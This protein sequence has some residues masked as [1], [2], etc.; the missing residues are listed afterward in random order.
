M[1]QLAEKTMWA[2]IAVFTAHY[3]GTE[4]LDHEPYFDPGIYAAG[5]AAMVSVSFI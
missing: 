3:L 2:P 4:G 1:S 5:G